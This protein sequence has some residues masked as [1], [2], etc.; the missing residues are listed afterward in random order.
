MGGQAVEEQA[1]GDRTDEEQVVGK[2]S[3]REQA[4]EEQTDRKWK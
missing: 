3:A 1:A 2:Q 4:D